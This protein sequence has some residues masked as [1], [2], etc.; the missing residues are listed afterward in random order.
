MNINLSLATIKSQCW[1]VV[2]SFREIVFDLLL[3]K[4]IKKKKIKKLIDSM[5]SSLMDLFD[6]HTHGR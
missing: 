1:D 2:N 4:D 3:Q 5:S 6:C